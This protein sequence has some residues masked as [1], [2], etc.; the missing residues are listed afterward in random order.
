MPKHFILHA[1]SLRQTFVHCG[2]FS[3][4][5][6]RRCMDRVSVPSVGVTLSGPLGV[7][8]LVSHYLT[9]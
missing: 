8:A 5:A 1:A 4:A 6:T 7:I 2:R 3:T 9:N